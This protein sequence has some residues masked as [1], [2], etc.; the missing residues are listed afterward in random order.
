W[1]GPLRDNAHLQNVKR[2]A[3]LR[4]FFSGDSFLYTSTAPQE[5]RE[6]RSWPAGR[7]AGCPESRKE[8]PAPPQEEWK[9]WLL[10]TKKKKELDS[11]LTSSA[12]E[13][14]LAGMTR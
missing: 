5:R 12:V 10:E 6:Q 14:R 3:Q 8:L 11:G 4:A 2:A 7:R 9:L 1:S 13:E